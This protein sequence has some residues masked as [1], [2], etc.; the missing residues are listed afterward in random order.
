MTT[1][2]PSLDLEFV[3]AQFPTFDEPTLD[4]WAFFENAGGSYACRQTIDRLHRYYTTTKVQPYAPYPASANAGA[5]MDNAHIRLG[6]HLNLDPDEVHMGPSTSQNTYVLA[7]ALRAGWN[8]G[9]EIVVTDQD[10]EANSGVWRRLAETGIT[11]RE[12][13]VDPDSGSLD[14]AAL[15]DLL[16]PRTRLVAFPHCSNIVAEVNPVAEIC[17]QVRAAGAVSVVDGVSAAPHGLPDVD[18][19]GADVYLFSAY[20]TYGP[21]QGVMTVRRSVMETLTNQSHWFN[22]GEVHKRLVPAGPDHAQVA[23]MNGVCDYIDL[24][25]EHHYADGAPAA[26]RA[27]RVH[28][29][30]R[31]HETEL[32]SP[33]LDYLGTRSDARLVGPTTAEARVP[34][35]SLQLSSDPGEAAAA[36]ADHHVMAGAGDFYAVRLIEAIGMPANPGV[37]RVSFVH[38][39]SPAEIDQLV[40]A[41]DA[42]L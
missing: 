35:V 36:L 9:D 13:K 40:R 26:D 21:H 3:R 27:R 19:L 38:Y 20:K 32:L 2:S 10:H 31:A 5:Q 29:L 4:K 28:D 1:E 16:G 15:G 23:A 25:H 8:D 42:V 11:V 41:L 14:P 7:H 6:G 33:L 37:L 12:W 39:T 22:D 34:T 24:L 30:I 17:A 18:A